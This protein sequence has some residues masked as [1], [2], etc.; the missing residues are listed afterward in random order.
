[1]VIAGGLSWFE[2]V[3]AYFVSAAGVSQCVGGFRIG[4]HGVVNE[5]SK[6]HGRYS[7]RRR[8]VRRRPPPSPAFGSHA[9]YL[10]H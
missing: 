1:M 4:V 9:S 10:R 3:A 8:L 6:K 2:P 7:R 5:D